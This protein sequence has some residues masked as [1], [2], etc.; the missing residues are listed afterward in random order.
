[1]AHRIIIIT[2]KSQETLPS[3]W[4]ACVFC[5]VRAEPHARFGCPRLRDSSG[6]LAP[7]PRTGGLG[8]CPGISWKN[9]PLSR[10]CAPPRPRAAPAYLPLPGGPAGLGRCPPPTAPAARPPQRGRSAWGRNAL[11]RNA[12]PRRRRRRP[13]PPRA[14]PSGRPRPCSSARAA[15]GGGGAAAAGT[16]PAGTPAP[17][18]GPAALGD[19]SPPRGS[20]R[21]PAGRGAAAA[22]KDILAAGA[23]PRAPEN[24]CRWSGA[25]QRPH[26]RPGAGRPRPPRTFE[27]ELVLRFE[28]QDL[29][30]FRHVPPPRRWRHQA[31]RGRDGAGGEG[32]GEGGEKGRQAGGA[33]PAGLFTPSQAA[34]QRRRERRCGPDTAGQGGRRLGSSQRTRC[35]GRDAGRGR[36]G[37][38][39]MQHGAAPRAAALTSG[40]AARLPPQPRGRPA[41][42]PPAPSAARPALPC[43]R[44]R[45]RGLLASLG[46]LVWLGLRPCTCNV[47]ADKDV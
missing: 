34:P 36:E 37:G 20:G 12:L 39:M 24:G 38:G 35:P 41:R 16:G 10:R 22:L 42:P 17:R 4:R 15:G 9:T 18:C 5:H 27:F 2:W 23:Q 1:M 26:R 29:L 13:G 25:G 44:R 8:T 14:L 3:S 21:G 7:H 45:S 47:T 19:A 32:R 31:E 28:A 46:V 30:R 11:F 6:S 43:G 40:T 33:R